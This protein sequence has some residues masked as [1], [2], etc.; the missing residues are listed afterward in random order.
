MYKFITDE[1]KRNIKIKTINFKM[2][3]NKMKID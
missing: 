1:N 2:K 3:W